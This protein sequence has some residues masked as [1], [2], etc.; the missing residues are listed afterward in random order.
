MRTVRISTIIDALREHRDSFRK[1]ANDEDKISISKPMVDIILVIIST[2][3]NSRTSNFEILA[4]D[5]SIQNHECVRIHLNPHRLPMSERNQLINL[6][7]GDIVWF[8]GLSVRK[9]YISDS[10]TTKS[11]TCRSEPLSSSSSLQKISTVICDFH[12][13][14]LNANS[15]S[16]NLAKLATVYSVDAMKYIRINPEQFTNDA[17]SVNNTVHNVAEWFHTH[18]LAQLSNLKLIDSYNIEQ[19]NLERYQ[20]R[21]I[22]DL[23]SSCLFSDIVVRI[24]QVDEDIPLPWAKQTAWRNVWRPKETVSRAILVDPD[25]KDEKDSI[26]IIMNRKTERIFGKVQDAFRKHQ[27]CLLRGVLTKLNVNHHPHQIA[28]DAEKLFLVSTPTTSLEVLERSPSPQMLPAS[29]KSRQCSS[30][31]TQ[32]SQSLSRTGARQLTGIISS[33]Q[34]DGSRACDESGLPCHN[35]FLQLSTKMDL[36]MNG[37]QFRPAIVSIKPLSCGENRNNVSQIQAKASPHI[38]S[39]L[40]GSKAPGDLLKNEDELKN[41]TRLMQGLLHLSVPLE[42]SLLQ[43]HGDHEDADTII[44]DVSLQSMLF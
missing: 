10:E 15:D 18:H 3:S 30:Q 28:M 40:L 20:R 36:T 12:H 38:V 34:F 27:L 31:M 21:K 33:I 41:A 43:N 44:C 5:H 14:W 7:K 17:G 35:A 16:R 29:K 23:T 11:K 2:R 8:H 26:S 37:L 6:K 25:M 22:R 24:I 4:G 9:E 1:L 32:E 42:W 13:S 19:N 39:V